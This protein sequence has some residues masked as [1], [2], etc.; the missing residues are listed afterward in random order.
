MRWYLHL[1]SEIFVRSDKRIHCAQSV[2][3]CHVF[4]GFQ[5]YGYMQYYL[6]CCL[7]F[8]QAACSQGQFRN[9]SQDIIGYLGMPES[10]ILP[11]VLIRRFFNGGNLTTHTAADLPSIRELKVRSAAMDVT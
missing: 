3:I 4:L 2:V 9:E 8:C 10:V 1:V 5:V 6:V 11:D 7:L